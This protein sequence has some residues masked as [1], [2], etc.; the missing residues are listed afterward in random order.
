MSPTKRQ[1]DV[2]FISLHLPGWTVRFDG[3]SRRY[4]AQSPRFDQDGVEV[5]HNTAEEVVA[6]A[7][8]LMLNWQPGS[9]IVEAAKEAKKLQQEKVPAPVLEKALKEDA[10]RHVG[11]PTPAQKQAYPPTAFTG[12][13]CQ[14][15]KSLD[16]L[17]TGTCGV[18]LN[19]GEPTSCT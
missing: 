19:C 2:T 17:K 3:W 14:H 8:V 15:C 12:E 9:G 5:S 13:E 7:H 10:P 6:L 4:T 1:Q 11:A 18:C 16:V